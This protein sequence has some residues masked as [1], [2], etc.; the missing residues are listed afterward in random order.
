MCHHQKKKKKARITE[1]EFEASF[2]MNAGSVL[3]TRYSNYTFISN[4]INIQKRRIATC[5]TNE[6]SALSITYSY[7]ISPYQ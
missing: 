6:A 7:Q 5:T 4:H 2:L 1:K 3:K